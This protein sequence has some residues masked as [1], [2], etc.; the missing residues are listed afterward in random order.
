MTEAKQLLARA[1]RRAPE[2]DLTIEDI[3]QRRGRAQRH[4]RMSAT[5][6]GVGVTLAL[7]AASLVAAG[8]SRGRGRV[9]VPNGG[10][11]LPPATKLPVTI[12]PNESSYE[13]LAYTSSCDETNVGTSCVE[14]SVDLESWWRADDSGRIVVNAQENFGAHPGSFDPGTFHTEGDLTGFPLDPD[15]LRA[16]LLERSGENGASPRPDV[17]PSPR[18][19]LEEGLLWNSIR[20]YLGSTR[21]LNAT[22]ALRAAMLEVLATVPMVS[23]DVQAHDPSGRDAI[24][25]RFVAYAEDTVVFVDPATH[26]FLGMTG[27]YIETGYRGTVL[28][29]SAGR[30]TSIDDVPTGA[31]R[32][33]PTAPQATPS[34]RAIRPS[35]PFTNR[36]ASSAESSAAAST[37]SLMATD[38]GTSSLQSNS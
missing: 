12:G 26:D 27:S 32:S 19:P 8:S 6:V 20:D 14:N 7:I 22:P 29:A 21:Y 16:F 37:A 18:V 25:L 28:V 9:Q 13:H 38:V 34:S 24:A 35:T 11:G 10:I 1:A 5:I 3:W 4:R 15:A 30:T 2:P 31:D 17:T 36:L 23:V 33:I